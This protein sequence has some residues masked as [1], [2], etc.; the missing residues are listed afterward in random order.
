MTESRGGEG[1]LT[2]G[3]LLC[4]QLSGLSLHV[5]KSNIS[6]PSWLPKEG[7]RGGRE[8]SMLVRRRS[9]LVP[10]ECLERDLFVHTM[11]GGFVHGF[12]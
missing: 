3:S 1:W 2:N 11:R 10:G 12:V 9:S 5:K 6:W 8:A 4:K 7:S